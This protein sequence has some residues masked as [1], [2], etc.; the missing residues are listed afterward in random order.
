MNKISEPSTASSQTKSR[1]II[2]PRGLRG[3]KG[4]SGTGGGGT[5]GLSGPSGPIRTYHPNL[6]LD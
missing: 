6:F 5:G 4:F 1:G 3:E 2:G